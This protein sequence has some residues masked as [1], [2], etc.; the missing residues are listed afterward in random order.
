MSLIGKMAARHGREQLA[1]PLDAA[2]AM[3]R[4]LLAAALA[5][6]LAAPAAQAVETADFEGFADGTLLGTELANVSFSHA[7]VVS[8]GLSLNEFEFPPRSGSNV[9]SDDGAPI[10]IAF[11]TP[12]PSFSAYFTY[13]DTV[14]VT[15]FDQHGAVAASATS[16][17]SNNTLL[18]GVAGSSPNELIALAS[19]SGIYRVVIEG[20]AEGSSF[21][22]DDMSISPVPEPASAATLLAGLATLAVVGRQRRRVR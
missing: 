12:T 15:A 18:S 19:A 14:T 21:T 10:E 13:L 4:F 9:A 20:M 5:I 8:S 22:M 16:L 2:V 17:F 3:R 7:I 1:T 6:T 11:G